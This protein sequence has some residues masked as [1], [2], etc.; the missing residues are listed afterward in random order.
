MLYPGDSPQAA[1]GMRESRPCKVRTCDSV[2]D[3]LHKEEVNFQLNIQDKTSE[4]WACSLIRTEVT[5]VAWD[6]SQLYVTFPEA[7]VLI[8]SLLN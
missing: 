8:Y 6:H 5:V 7:A 1:G 4:C 3:D 2:N